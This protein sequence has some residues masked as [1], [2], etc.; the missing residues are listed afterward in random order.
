MRFFAWTHAKGLD[1]PA[2]KS[3]HESAFLAEL[4]T[5]HATPT[6]K[7]HLASLRM[8]FD[9]L[10]TGQIMETNPAAAVRAA[11]H[12]VKKGLKADQARELLTASRSPLTSRTAAPSSTP[13]A[14]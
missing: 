11:N 5:E 1:V 3:D 9:W 4:A 12:V 10:I 13:R 7:Q 14:N 6:V 2:I 8:L